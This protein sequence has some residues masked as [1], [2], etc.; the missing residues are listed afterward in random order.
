MNGKRRPL[1]NKQKRKGKKSIRE[2][3]NIG[4]FG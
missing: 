2:R 1:E 3:L 4:L